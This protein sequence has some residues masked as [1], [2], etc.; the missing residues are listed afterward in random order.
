M[1]AIALAAA[2]A[3]ATPLRLPAEP[4]V[5][6]D[7]LAAD[8]AR[9][10]IPAGNTGK[11]FLLTGGQFRSIDGFATKKGRGDRLMG[12]GAATVGEGAVYVGNRGDSR[13]WA[14]DPRSMEK[15]GSAEMPSTPDGVFYVASTKEVWVTTPR[16]RS[17]QILDVKDPLAPKLVGTMTTP[18]V[19]E[20]YA[21][22]VRKGIVYTNLE[23]ADRTLAIDARSRTVVSTWDS[24]CGKDGPRGIAIDSGRDVLFIACS[25][26]GV[27]AVDAKTGAR[28]GR[29]EAGDGVDNIDYLPSKR[30][31]YASAGRSEKVTVAYLQD[32]GSVKPLVTARVG[33]GS[34]TVVATED[35]TAYAAD[36]G[37]GELWVLKPVE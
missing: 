19:P 15:K 7:Y 2:A 27:M 17:L 1:I 18:G 4:P 24:G 11:V 12:P 34:R 6:M 22:D 20:G 10:W 33:K 36:S 32:D 14:I 35:G 29:L 37:G 25:S 8:G 28:K 9:V 26:A 13:I 21:V 23:D 5:L 30:L 3:T 31:L 16:E